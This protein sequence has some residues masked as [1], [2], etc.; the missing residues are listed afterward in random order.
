MGAYYG[1]F[2]NAFGLIMERDETQNIKDY[3]FVTTCKSGDYLSRLN[4]ELQEQG[5]AY[6]RP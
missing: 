2:G 1:V 4:G 6:V 3:Q 5:Y